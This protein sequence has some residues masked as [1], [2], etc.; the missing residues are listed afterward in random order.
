MGGNSLLSL[1]ITGMTHNSRHRQAIANVINR[2]SNTLI[3]K[4]GR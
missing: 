1:A 2:K 3:Q 4:V